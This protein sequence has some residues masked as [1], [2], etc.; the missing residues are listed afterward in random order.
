MWAHLELKAPQK[1]L[2]IR[3][4]GGV[5][6]ERSFC[7]ADHMRVFDVPAVDGFRLGDVADPP[8]TVNRLDINLVVSPACL[9]P[10]IHDGCSANRRC[11]EWVLQCQVIVQ[12][13]GVGGFQHRNYLDPLAKAL[14]CI[15]EGPS[16]QSVQEMPEIL[17]RFDA[18][19]SGR[20]ILLF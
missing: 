6:Q 5:S 3:S 15:A 13:T 14:E 1:G 10:T 8:R 4:G 7:S 9:G 19:Q 16:V 11:R 18:I 17:G 2:C 20:P 12:S